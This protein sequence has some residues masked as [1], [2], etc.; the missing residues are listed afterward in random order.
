MGQTTR[1]QVP[2]TAQRRL[3]FCIP[4]LALQLK[5]SEKMKQIRIQRLGQMHAAAKVIK[6]VS[7]L[8]H[9]SFTVN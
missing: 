8:Q 9:Q 6:L 2:I 7:S 1:N 3:S 5:F 4:S